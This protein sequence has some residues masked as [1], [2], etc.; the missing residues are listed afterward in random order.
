MAQTENGQKVYDYYVDVNIGTL[1]FAYDWCEF[2][3]ANRLDNDMYGWHK[4][5]DEFAEWVL[6]DEDKDPTSY[7]LTKE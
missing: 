5:C 4:W 1:E 7:G 3:M 2:F 6:S